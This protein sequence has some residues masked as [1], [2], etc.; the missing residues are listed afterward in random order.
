MFYFETLV[1]NE[2]RAWN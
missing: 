1:T 2:L